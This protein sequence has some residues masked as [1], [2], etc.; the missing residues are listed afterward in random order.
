MTRFEVARR[1][2]AAGRGRYSGQI[3]PHQK[4]GG[5]DSGKAD[6][7]QIGESRSLPA[8]YSNLR[9]GGPDPSFEPIAKYRRARCRPRPP[10]DGQLE[11]CDHAGDSDHVLRAG[12][13]AELL[14]AS[15][16]DRYDRSAAADVQKPD[17]F[18]AVKLMG[19]ERE[20]VDAQSAHLGR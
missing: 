14:A 12:P 10:R 20:Q 7:E 16:Q 17:A 1:A 13:A 5:I 2:G 8:V 4:L 11:G 19:R 3:E 6:V 18:R 9:N 15:L